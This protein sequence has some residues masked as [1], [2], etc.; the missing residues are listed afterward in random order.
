MKRLTILDKDFI[1][2]ESDASAAILNATSTINTLTSPLMDLA[3]KDGED[4]RT[5]PSYIELRATVN[6]VES[7]NTVVN[8]LISAIIQKRRTFKIADV[9]L[10][11]EIYNAI[12]RSFDV[13]KASAIEQ[14][15]SLFGSLD[16]FNFNPATETVEVTDSGISEFIR[17]LGN[18]REA[19]IQSLSSLSNAANNNDI[20]ET[21]HN[22]KNITLLKEF[23]VHL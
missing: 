12:N 21:T 18:L 6:P 8:K 15:C 19:A 13:N 20:N 17:K 16:N 2:V 5:C 9:A 23:I 10:M 14:A 1:L 11:S 4:V 22:L 7:V 3:C